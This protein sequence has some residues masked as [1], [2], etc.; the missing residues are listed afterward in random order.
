MRLTIK[1]FFTIC[2][3]L[4]LSLSSPAF[5]LLGPSINSDAYQTTDIGY[6]IGTFD[7]GAPKNIAQE[8]RRNA[9]V[10]YYGFDYNFVTF[11]QSNG[12][13]AVE[14]AFAVMNAVTNADKIQ[15]SQYPFDSQQSLDASALDLVDL[16]SMTLGGIMEQMG[17]AQSV[18]YDWALHDR[19]LPSGAQCSPDP[20]ING[21]EYLVVQRN[22]DPVSQIYSA[23]VNG[24]LYTYGLAESCGKTGVFPDVFTGG[25]VDAVTVPLPVD[26]TSTT[27]T[28]VSECLDIWAVEQN[29]HDGPGYPS[30]A[31]A[32]GTYYTGLTYDD[33]GGLHYLLSTNTVAFESPAPGSQLESTNAQL[34]LLQTSDLGALFGFAQT[35]PPGAVQ[36]QFPGL[37]INN[38][39]TFFTVVSNPIVVSYFTNL[40]GSPVATFVVKTNGYF[41]TAQTN[42][43]YQFGNVVIVNEHTNTSAQLQTISLGVLNGAPAGA[44]VVTNVTYKKITLTNTISGDYYLL[45]PNSCGFN[46]V[47]TLLKNNRAGITTNVI[48]S[49]TNTATGFAGSESIV[50]YFTNNWYEYYACNFTTSG[51]ALY[52]GI[53]KVQFVEA[54]YD[55]T[56]GQTFTPVTNFYTMT[57]LNATN[58]KTVVQTFMR[59]A[60]QP[61]ILMD[62]SDQASPNAT[63]IGIAWPPFTRSI[64]YTTDPQVNG[65]TPAAGPGTITD[66]PTTF[67]YNDAG[68]IYLLAGSVVNSQNAFLGTGPSFFA[69]GSFDNSTNAPVIYPYGSV[70]N[71]ENEIL[72]QISP[73]T[74]P[75]ATNTVPYSQTFTAS[76][77]TFQPPFTWSLAIDPSTLQ[78]TVLPAGLN[79]SPDGTISGTPL[80]NP[81]GPYDFIIQMTDSL[82]R[83]VTWNY[84]INIDPNQ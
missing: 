78:Q 1:L 50:T 10:I 54:D 14:S 21:E 5:S 46:L 79:L 60:T 18:R 83:N 32:D 40:P 57:M 25:T 20:G 15:L 7:V 17:L 4:T 27:Y 38:F 51:P 61:D 16:K 24:T 9:G 13:A 70:S 58:G 3:L 56:L 73:T 67:S 80:N 47:K 65:S 22:Y 35:N 81:T 39:S 44:D 71:L 82:G 66:Y 8:Y 68:N 11:F 59:I 69:W 43:L 30:G 84:S 76:G 41:Y 45:P 77:G 74:L 19:F 49:S 34:Q 36:A 55:S 33:V 53:G 26:T 64:S 12:M 2:G 42:Y 23:Y 37:V 52:Q 75:D 28:P 48:T 63:Q 29:V 31:L 72:V 62:A 6:N